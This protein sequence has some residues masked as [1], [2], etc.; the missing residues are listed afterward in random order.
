VCGIGGNDC[1]ECQQHIQAS[2][3]LS[4]P[5]KF[6]PKTFGDVTDGIHSVFRLEFRTRCD[7][8]FRFLE[9]QTSTDSNPHWDRDGRSGARTTEVPSLPVQGPDHFVPVP[10]H[11]T[12]FAVAKD[13]PERQP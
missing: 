6:D 7:E 2:R 5:T 3:P 13:L 8:N 9:N 10:F 12:D 11:Q 4:L 1:T